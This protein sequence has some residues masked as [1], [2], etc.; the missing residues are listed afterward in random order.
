[1]NFSRFLPFA[2]GAMLAFVS[3]DAQAQRSGSK[4]ANVEVTTVPT[5]PYA[6]V[7]L[8]LIHI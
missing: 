2:F 6:I 1:M 4:S 8:S 5:V 7:D 3:F